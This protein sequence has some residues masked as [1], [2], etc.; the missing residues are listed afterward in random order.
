MEPKLRKI[1]EKIHAA[2]PR[3]VVYVTGGAAQAITWLVEL[4]GSSRTL[5]EAAIP[6]SPSAVADLL[7]HTP[8]K[9]TSPETARALAEKAYEKGLGW[10]GRGGACHRHRLY[11]L[12]RHA[13]AQT[14]KASS[15]RRGAGK[16]SHYHL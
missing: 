6:Y 10:T 13:A 5:I 16:E 9:F 15:N 2:P 7:G 11:G 8:K 1:L 3:A 12:T 14:G 4:P